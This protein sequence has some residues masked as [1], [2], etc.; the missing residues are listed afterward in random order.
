MNDEKQ[1]T[2]GVYT[3]VTQ[4]LSEGGP[5]GITLYTAR[6]DNYVARSLSAYWSLTQQEAIDLGVRLITEA[7]RAQGHDEAEHH[8]PAMTES[9]AP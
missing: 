9:E 4:F 6:G 7:A 8:R 1:P 5:R 2:F 3:E